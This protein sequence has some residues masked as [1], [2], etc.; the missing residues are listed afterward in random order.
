MDL[1][2]KI[3][4]NHFKLLSLQMVATTLFIPLSG[5]TQEVNDNDSK[6]NIYQDYDQQVIDNESQLLKLKTQ[7]DQLNIAYLKDEKN[8]HFSVGEK[9]KKT[10]PLM[11][12]I[13][14]VRFHFQLTR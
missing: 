2:K 6:S 9:I 12:R 10:A 7:V 5:F 14:Q 3:I 13:E 11:L 8:L 4:S 1:F